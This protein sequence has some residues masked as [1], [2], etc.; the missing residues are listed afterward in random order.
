MSAKI[1]T[2]TR[3]KDSNGDR[4]RIGDIVWVREYPDK[5]VGGSL[6][7]EGVVEEIDGT[8]CATYYD[9]GEEESTALSVFPVK[10]RTLLT[11]EEQRKYW[12]TR[13]LGE[14]PPE[15]L[16]KRDMYDQANIK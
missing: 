7:Y 3:Y 16:Y 2:K 6:D 1:G 13:F 10:G 14:E 15:Y 11:E 4:I 8:V 9:I 5:Y 12:K